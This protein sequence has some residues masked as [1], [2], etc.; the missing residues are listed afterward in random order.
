MSKGKDSKPAQ[1]GLNM[2]PT[3]ADNSSDAGQRP[4]LDARLLQFLFRTS[5]DFIFVAEYQG[6]SKTGPLL[7]INNLARKKLGYTLRQL[8]DRFPAGVLAPETAAKLPA[9]LA[10][11]ASRKSVREEFV[12]V[13]KNGRTIPTE[14]DADL[15]D[16]E[17]REVILAVCRDISDRQTIESA[18]H[19]LLEGLE[20]QVSQRTAELMDINR[21]LQAEILERA[22]AEEALVEKERQLRLITDNMLDIVM[23]IDPSGIIKYISPSCKTVLG[24]DS[25]NLVGRPFFDHI[26]PD[27]IVIA[28]A[29]FN[30]AAN[31]G[32]PVSAQYRLRHAAGHWLWTEGVSKAVRDEIGA[33]CGIIT[34]CRDITGRKRIEQQLKYQAIRDPV[35]GLHNRTYFEI[36]MARLTDPDLHPVGLIV[37]DLDGLKYINDTL[38]HDIGDQLLANLADLIRDPFRANEVVARIGGDEFAVILP[39]ADEASLAAGRA[40]IIAAIEAYNAKN[41]TIPLCVSVGTAITGPTLGING[42]FKEADNSM[43]REKLLSQHSSRR[44]VVQALKKAL[45]VRDFVT[46]GHATRLRDLTLRLAKACGFPDYKQTDICLFAKFHDIGKVGIPDHILFKPENLTVGELKVMRSHAEI[47]HRIAVSTPDLEP[48][49]DWILKHHEW[50]NGKGYPLGLKGEKIP[51]ECRMLAI[52]DAYDAMT[53][54]RPYRKAISQAEALAEIKRCAGTQFDPELVDRFLALFAA[55]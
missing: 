9:F 28:M 25:A 36:E 49:A 40:R 11:L 17:G 27:D 30:N 43:Y 16:Y 26:H 54:D 5:R 4:G 33:V 18:W 51:V 12:F 53:N 21:Q 1:R 2:L 50:W 35:T 23:Q 20:S 48:I 22:G 44:Y 10:R 47:G 29:D 13:A 38:G 34:S 14:L 42:L 37:C 32:S 55:T 19:R 24:I 46:E 31:S 52:A 8:A 39:K 3:T 15:I 6:P 7:E 45:E 41:P